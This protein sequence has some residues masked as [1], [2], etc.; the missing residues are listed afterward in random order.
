[1][2]AQQSAS[3]SQ[4]PFAPTQ[5]QVPS[6]QAPPKQSGETSEQVEPRVAAHV[7]PNTHREQQPESLTWLSGGEPAGRQ[8][9]TPPV[10]VPFWQSCSEAHGAPSV[11]RL[12]SPRWHDLPSQH[13]AALRQGQPMGEQA[14]VA[15]KHCCEA[16]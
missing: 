8:R 14:H 15:P 2:G 1:V 9:Q 3:V 16:H 13:S 7:S 5:V 10:Q 4:M 6:V 12:Q 11:A